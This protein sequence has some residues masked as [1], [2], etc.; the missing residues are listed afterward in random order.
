MACKKDDSPPPF[1]PVAQALIDDE[2][3][4]DYL[5]SHYYIPAEGG[6]TFGTVDT[7]MN[8]E[9]ALFVDQRLDTQDVIEN[10]ISYKLYY[11]VENEGENLAPTSSDSVLV[12]YRGF[13]LD[14]IKFDERLSYSWLS[15]TSV[16]RGWSLGFPNYSGGVN[17]SVPGEPIDVFG[18]GNGVL[19][20]P[21]GLAYGN[22]GTQGI[23]SNENLLFHIRLGSVQ[24]ADHE[25]DA[26]L[27]SYEDL[28]GDLNPN[29]DDSDLDGIPDYFDPDDDNDGVLTRNELE[30]KTYMILVGETE[31]I[32][33]SNEYE[34]DRKIED[35][36][37]VTI[38]TAVVLDSNNDGTPDYLDPETN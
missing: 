3:L 1:D 19:F 12:N 23:G 6:E 38:Y 20:L 28:N 25:G 30:L 18:P 7:I 27:S 5:K 11:F 22:F 16:I 13:F 10:E 2:I 29:T 24:R 31:P 26:L 9:T 32:L 36:I 34:Y 33:A 35:D 17:I 14:S 21:S 37:N 8:G 4:V 15:L